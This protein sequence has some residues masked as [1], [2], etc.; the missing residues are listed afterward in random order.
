MAPWRQS[1]GEESTT[2]Q[3]GGLQKVVVLA[4]AMAVIPH[5]PLFA[6]QRCRMGNGDVVVVKC[7]VVGNLPITG[8]AASALSQQRGCSVP[9]CSGFGMNQLQLLLER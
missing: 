9:G 1:E 8:Q 7:V 2:V 4:E 3:V 6:V 5:R